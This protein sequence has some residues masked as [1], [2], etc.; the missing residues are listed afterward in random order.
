MN[1]YIKNANKKIHNRIS[2]RNL[3]NKLMTIFIVTILSMVAFTTVY[4]VFFT[5]NSSLKDQA[6]WSADKFGITIPPYLENFTTAWRRANVPR[7]FLNSAITTLGG[8][9]LCYIICIFAAYAATKLRFKGRNSIFIFLIMSMM[10]PI[11]VILYPFFKIMYDFNLSNTYLGL[12]LAYLVT[13]SK[14]MEN[15]VK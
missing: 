6:A 11:Q 9:L 8:V 3:G 15:S 13:I 2:L 7:T 4:P 5:I 14:N 12:I 1:K 10:I